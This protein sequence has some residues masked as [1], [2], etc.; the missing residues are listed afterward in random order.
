MVCVYPGCTAP[1]FTDA[2]LAKALPAQA[3]AAY[4]TAKER[5]AEQRI[6][7]ELEAGFEQ[8][9]QIERAKVGDGALRALAARGGASQLHTLR[10][11]LCTG[12]S[13]AGVAAVGRG[14]PRLTALDL[15]GSG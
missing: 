7:A 4:A 5:V 1:P 2:V 10:L 8:R 3:F 11:F 13:G 15:S 14:C 9:L 6:N 12:V